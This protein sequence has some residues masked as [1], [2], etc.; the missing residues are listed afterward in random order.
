MNE[1]T[2]GL[3]LAGVTAVGVLAVLWFMA[4]RERRTASARHAAQTL[5]LTYTR[6]LPAV[7]DHAQAFHFYKR[8]SGHNIE[9]VVHGERPEGQLWAFDHAFRTGVGA[10][11]ESHAQSVVV[12]HSASLKLP[13]FL[14]RPENLVDK[15]G[16]AMGQDDIDFSDHP[17]FSRLLHLSGR[18]EAAVRR[19]FTDP[20][21]KFCEEHPTLCVEGVGPRLACYY[22][23]ETLAGEKLVELVNAALILA[24]LLR[25]G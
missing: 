19:A 5:H 8:G 21:C 4:K 11:S 20:I 14:L 15:I 9:H 2:A 3:M 1:M 6:R 12:L 24:K 17:E 10:G 22:N 18:D 16:A 7:R 23:D 25:T 13:E